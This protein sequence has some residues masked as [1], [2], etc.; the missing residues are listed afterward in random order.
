M[1]FFFTREKWT[2]NKRVGRY[3]PSSRKRCA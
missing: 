2:Q 3:K 1:F